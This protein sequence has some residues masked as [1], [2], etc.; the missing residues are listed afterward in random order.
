MNENDKFLNSPNKSTSRYLLYGMPRFGA[1]LVLGIEGWALFALY[2]IGYGVAPLLV[3]FALAMGYLSVAA[4]QFLLGWLSDSKYTR[5]GRR[6]PYLI[7]FSPL[8]GISF[9]FV[10]IPALVLPDLN[11][12][13]TL[14]I[15]LLVWDV[16]FRFSY[17]VTTPY[18]SWTAEQFNVTER[19]KVSQF[20]NIFSMVGN[21]VMAVV[22]LLVLTGVFDKVSKSPNVI[23]LEFIVIVAIFAILFIVLFYLIVFLMPTEPNFKIESSVT[24]NLKKIVKNKTFM[25]VVFMQGITSIALAI[26]TSIMLYYTEVVL[27]LTGSDYIAI[28]AFL[29]IGILAFLYM[30]TKLIQKKGK[31]RT[32]LNILLLGIVFLPITLFGLL[33]IVSNIIFGAIFIVGIAAILGGWYLFPYLM[34]ADLAEDDEKKTGELKAG[35][36]T[37]FPSIILNLFQAFGLLV[38]GIVL[39]LPPMGGLSYSIGLV[40]WG[41]IC[42]IVLICAWLYTKKYVVL[43]FEWEKK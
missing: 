29:L 14:F 3:A 33:P 36:F 41:P 7:I 39:S 20:Q 22:T 11:D 4:S 17:G 1:A 30:W 16:L 19:P 32:L 25:K 24:T 10:L 31:K 18:Q 13:N 28:A 42:S 38:I 5:W 21:G 2:T 43:D 6:K 9:I 37:G 40:I 8:L 34:Y 23:P 26:T 15:W 12:K 27:D 35:L